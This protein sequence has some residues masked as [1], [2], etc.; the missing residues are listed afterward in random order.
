MLVEIPTRSPIVGPVGWMSVPAVAAPTARV[1]AEASAAINHIADPSW[2]AH[3]DV[4]T[5]L[6]TP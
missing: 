4:Y 3:R 6:V 2:V 1:R 5:V